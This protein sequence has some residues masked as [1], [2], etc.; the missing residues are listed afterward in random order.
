MYLPRTQGFC[1]LLLIAFAAAICC[2]GQTP[3]QV[4]KVEPPSWWARSSVNPVRLLIRGSNL[5]RASVQIVGSGLRIASLPK[6]N[7]RGTY[8][9]VDVAIAPIANFVLHHPRITTANALALP[10][11]HPIVSSPRPAVSNH[12]WT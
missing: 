8:L 3:P 9:F 5:K 10:H 11:S 7:E 2:S 12:R 1:F 4:L 6:P